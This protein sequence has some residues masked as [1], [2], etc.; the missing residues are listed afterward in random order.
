M[1]AGLVR[2]CRVPGARD[3]CR[4]PD[5]LAVSATANRLD[6][7]GFRCV[8]TR[9]VSYHPMSKDTAGRLQINVCMALKPRWSTALQNC[10]RRGTY[11]SR[12]TK[13]HPSCHCHPSALCLGVFPVSWTDPAKRIRHQIH[14]SYR[15]FLATKYFL[16]TQLRC[17]AYSSYHYSSRCSYDNLTRTFWGSPL[18]VRSVPIYSPI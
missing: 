11:T 14:Y 16:S 17:L 4:P 18:S 2:T 6:P 1:L 9:K 3:P 10:L 13:S 7:P 8:L 12:T 5:R 15:L